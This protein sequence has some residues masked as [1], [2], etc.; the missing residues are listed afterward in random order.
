MI[1][2]SFSYNSYPTEN[3]AI[4]EKTRESTEISSI[5]NKLKKKK[6][7]NEERKKLETNLWS[8]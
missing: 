3:K 5:P 1:C 8:S 2:E 4:L 6:I 7:K